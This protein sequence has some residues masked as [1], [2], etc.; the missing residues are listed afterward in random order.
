MAA[1]LHINAQLG[2][3]EVEGE[4]QFVE[5]VYEDYKKN[6]LQKLIDAPAHQ[7][8]E[9]KDNASKSKGVIKRKSGP[10]CADRIL[11]VQAEGFFKTLRTAGQIKEKLAEKGTHY[12]SKHVAAAL[13]HLTK[14]GTIRRL[15]KDGGWQYQNP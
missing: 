8:D 12:E 14:R 2:I 3:I 11:T 6:L 9:K 7:N 5:Q 1:K 10:S 13:S 4:Q 15:K